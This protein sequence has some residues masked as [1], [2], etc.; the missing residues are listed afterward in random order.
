MTARAEQPGPPG[1]PGAD[2]PPG[3]PGDP[4]PAG[5]TG[6]KGDTGDAGP[7][8]AQG[9]A[10]ADGATGPQGPAGAK[11]DT[12]DT[13]T[14]GP[15]GIQG[16]AGSTGPQG[17]QGDPGITPSSANNGK[18][19]K[20]ASGAF[21]WAAITASDVS[22]L[23]DAAT[24]N[25]GT[26]AG[27]L[28]AGDDSRITGAAQKAQNLS[29]LAS[30]TTA[31]T[32]LGLGT[33]A[34]L[35]APAAG[36]AAAGQVAKGSDTRLSD[37]RQALVVGVQLGDTYMVPPIDIR[38]TA[39][40]GVLSANTAYLMRWTCPKTGTLSLAV[41]SPA[42]SGNGDLGIY[43]TGDANSTLFTLLT[44]STSFALAS[45]VWNASALGQAVVAGRDYWLSFA[46]DNATATFLR[47]IGLNSGSMTLPSGWAPLSG[48]ASNRLAG[49]TRPTS[50][51]L[52]ATIAA[53]GGLTAAAIGPPVLLARIT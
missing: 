50:F 6:P 1:P 25:T 36:N 21:V 18:W 52:P 4:G 3:P 22:G 41:Y 40:T 39:T 42:A 2:G 24:K 35:D 44:H 17:P 14:Q 28:A 48:G 16:P 7:T 29:D 27:T 43:D 11:G 20:T 33:A 12:G 31:R 34:V 5:T 53:V 23:G 47:T 45:G 9:P 10:G 13:G 51:P 38:A 26:A 19:L 8:G 30:A 49:G 32:N 37:A 46:A 15:Q